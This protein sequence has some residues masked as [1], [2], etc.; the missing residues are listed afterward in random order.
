MQ[1]GF[2]QQFAINWNQ[3]WDLV[4]GFSDQQREMKGCSVLMKLDE[5][6]NSGVALQGNISIIDLNDIFQF[7]DYASASGELR[8]ISEE[9]N[10]S[11]YFREGL[12]IFGALSVNQKK[13]GDLLLDS[14]LIT[15]QQL[16]ACLDT[17][18]RYGGHRRL[19]EILVEK[20]FLEF[21]KL[22]EVLKQQA[23]EAFFST[24]SWK[25]GMFYFYADR[26]PSKR[27]ILINERID[28]LLLEGMVRLDNASA[29]DPA[30][31]S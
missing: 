5:C 9:N 22:A 17:H 3:L 12:L 26:Y 28:R 11:F 13:I 6:H 24:F 27:E 1:G 20:G 23:R 30:V 21:E 10:A 19:G 7:F 8:I 29:T 18:A 31:K 16:A 14:S 15:S 25:K 4:G 2:F